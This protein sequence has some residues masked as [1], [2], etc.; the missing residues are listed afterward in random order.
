MSGGR[1]HFKHDEFAFSRLAAGKLSHFEH[2]DQLIDLLDRL[3]ECFTVT[4]N[5]GRDARELVIYHR[6]YI[7][8]LYIESAAAEH[9]SD[10]GEN[11]EF[12]FDEN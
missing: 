3:V 9:S 7:Q 6:A 12:V 10:A 4:D 1:G 8:S 2:I 11:S 5:G